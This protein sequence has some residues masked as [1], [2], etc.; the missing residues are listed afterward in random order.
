MNEELKPCPFCGSEEIELISWVDE[1][2]KYYRVLCKKCFVGTF[3]Y[4]YSK[5]AINSWN[6]RIN[7]NA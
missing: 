4:R 5:P 6:R 2:I 1:N 7:E 3:T